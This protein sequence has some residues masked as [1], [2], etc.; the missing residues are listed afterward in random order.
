[1]AVRW[2]GSD[3]TKRKVRNLSRNTTR[4]VR[5]LDS[6]CSSR[7]NGRVSTKPRATETRAIQGTAETHETHEIIVTEETI[8][9]I[10][11]Y[12]NIYIN[13]VIVLYRTPTIQ[14]KIEVAI[15]LGAVIWVVGEATE[16]REVDI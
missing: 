12:T 8:V 10:I 14:I 9:S 13:Y 15:L 11:I 2:N 16:Y 5:K 6:I 7:R 4:K 1:M 3:L